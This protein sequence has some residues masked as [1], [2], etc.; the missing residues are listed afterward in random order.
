MKNNQF[1]YESTP[2][3]SRN[4][5]KRWNSP[6]ITYR[7]T[8]IPKIKTDREFCYRIKPFVPTVKLNS[9]NNESN[10]SCFNSTFNL[11]EKRKIIKIASPPKTKRLIIIKS[12]KRENSSLFPFST[13]YKEYFLTQDKNCFTERN[14]ENS[15]ITR[16]QNCFSTNCIKQIQSYDENTNSFENMKIN[17]NKNNFYEKAP[18]S[19]KSLKHDKIIK[20]EDRIKENSQFGNNKIIFI[21]NLQ[22]TE[23]RNSPKKVKILN[24]R[25]CNRIFNYNNN[26]N[27]KNMTK[28][29][30]PRIYNNTS[31]RVINCSSK[32]K[33]KIPKTLFF[34]NTGFIGNYRDIEKI[35]HNTLNKNININNINNT[36][37]PLYTRINKI[38]NSPKKTKKI[39]YIK[40]NE[41]PK[42]VKNNNVQNLTF[43]NQLINRMSQNE[44]KIHN[45]TSVK[46]NTK[47][48]KEKEKENKNKGL[49]SGNVTILREQ[50]T[51]RFKIDKDIKNKEKNKYSDDIYRKNIEEKN[52]QLENKL[53]QIMEEN[54]KLKINNK[55]YFE[56]KNKYNQIVFEKNEIQNKTENIIKNQTDLLKKINIIENKTKDLILK[57]KLFYLEKIN[58]NLIDPNESFNM[59][60]KVKLAYLKYLIIK[61]IAKQ[62][63][64]LLQLFEIF[65]KNT[66]NT[67]ESDFQRK[68]NKYLRDLF[69]S[70]VRERKN[71]IHRFFTKFYFK[72]L[73][74][75]MK[76]QAAKRCMTENLHQSQLEIMKKTSEININETNNDNE[77]NKS[78]QYNI[79]VKNNSQNIINE[80]EKPNEVSETKNIEKEIKEE[81]VGN[82]NAKIVENSRNKGKH[83]RKLLMQ[84]NKERLETLRKNFYIFQYNGI[85][86]FFKKEIHKSNVIQN[87]QVQR[88]LTII[89]K[90]ETEEKLREEQ[91]REEEERK[92]AEQEKYLLK[93]NKLQIIVSKK[94][95]KITI[96]LKKIFEEWNLITKILSLNELNKNFCFKRTKKSKKK[97]KKNSESKDKEENARK[98]EK[99]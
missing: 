79:I 2:R 17:T 78:A 66:L 36:F 55:N 93:L 57:N 99:K 72:G 29:F 19:P 31:M 96:I 87:E 27:D 77:D 37:S 53:K 22:K 4:I 69:Y 43:K 64:N 26:I 67:M 95:R 15:F 14:N 94:D 52:K 59:E 56:L 6:E 83:L 47:L 38:Y 74:N 51:E 12:P 18:K 54:E 76:V 90:E 62:K 81:K 71:R 7:I 44:S 25:N 92:K 89:Q 35:E 60:R 20:Y 13:Q 32:E 97:K 88:A 48:Y 28:E 91:R 30:S 50:S 34:S 33:K 58:R 39:K 80:N 84:K 75:S 82:E 86:K 98:N 42:P 11:A 24:S 9:I 65:K 70:K 16:S 8:N 40:V 23:L 21:K 85:M 61:K 5:R 49:Y 10:N 41:I 68:R 63:Y 45:Y 3:Y 46:L 1:Y 73:L